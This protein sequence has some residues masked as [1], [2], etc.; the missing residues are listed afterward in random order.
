VSTDVDSAIDRLQHSGTLQRSG[1]S[2]DLALYAFGHT[3]ATEQLRRRLDRDGIRLAAVLDNNPL[4]Q[5][6][7]LG[8]VPIIAPEAITEQSGPSLV[9]IASRFYDEMR[10]QLL[11][12]GYAEEKILRVGDFSITTDATVGGDPDRGTQLLERLRRAHPDRHLVVCPFGAFGDVYW[13]LAYLP[14]FAAARQLPPAVPV[15]VGESCRQVARLFGYEDV[16]SL[17]QTAM[18]DLVAAVVRTQAPDATIAH[19]DR[20]YGRAAPVRVLDERFVAFTDVYRDLVYGLSDQTEPQTPRR[21]RL[22][23]ADRRPLSDG[24]AQGRTVLLAPYAKS[25]LPVAPSFWENTAELYASR[26]YTVATVVH[27]AEAAVPGTVALKVDIAELLQVAEHAGTFI[28]L[29]SG[30]CDVVHSARARKVHVLPDAY[31]SSTRHKVADFFALP[32]W[33]SVV[34]PVL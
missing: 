27:G 10:R 28:A 8:N 20:P 26:G 34:L 17:T 13:A 30:L 4:K 7:S 22:R 3:A 24:F 19:H 12:L 11:D 25:V 9:L 15:V 33:E 16:D 6:S 14:A 29:R 23:Q 1:T 31:Y 32:G 21:Q 5:G 18:D 2:K